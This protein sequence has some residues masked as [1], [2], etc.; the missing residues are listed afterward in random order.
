MIEEDVT[1]DE[2]PLEN[3][4]VADDAKTTDEPADTEE[5]LHGLHILSQS[6]IDAGTYSIRDVV[7]PL[8][9]SRSM[10]PGHEIGPMCMDLLKDD[11]LT[12]QSFA[13]CQPTYRTDGA[14]RR[15]VQFPGSFE[16]SVIN[17]T[18]PNEDLVETELS[19]FVKNSRK[20]NTDAALPASSLPNKKILNTIVEPRGS[21]NDNTLR[22]AVLQFTLPP[23]TYAT[24]MLRELTKES[25]AAQYQ[26]QLT[27]TSNKD[28][29]ASSAQ[30]DSTDVG[31]DTTAEGNALP[32]AKRLKAQQF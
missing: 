5:L 27:S 29:A 17:Y 23:G 13:T 14:Y 18:D 8:V 20:S 12:L 1:D 9:G 28:D 22:A 21:N 19:T 31:T 26:A 6:D 15:L 10:L 25:T 3:V 32:D 24:V 4:M 2:V 7:L 30:E 11:G 16:Y